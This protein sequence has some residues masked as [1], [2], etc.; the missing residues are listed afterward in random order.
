MEALG[1]A[2]EGFGNRF[3]HNRTFR[4]KGYK[5]GLAYIA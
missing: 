4:N 5:P 2:N 3:Y 1:S